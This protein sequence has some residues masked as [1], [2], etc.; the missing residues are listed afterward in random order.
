MIHQFFF[1][2]ANPFFKRHPLELVYYLAREKSVLLNE[3]LIISL[4]QNVKNFWEGRSMPKD[5]RPNTILNEFLNQYSIP[6]KKL[7]ISEM[8][9][10]FRWDREK[11]EFYLSNKQSLSFLKSTD[12]YVTKSTPPKFEDDPSFVKWLK[13]ALNLDVDKKKIDNGHDV[14]MKS[15][16]DEVLEID[17]MMPLKKRK[18]RE[19]SII[20]EKDKTTLEKAADDSLLTGIKLHKYCGFNGTEVFEKIKEHITKEYKFYDLVSDKE[21]EIFLLKQRV[22]ELEKYKSVFEALKGQIENT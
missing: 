22:Y 4:S 21:K 12:L 20:S 13:E 9:N 18:V 2:S 15:S 6:S 10:L 1:I 3:S 5:N 17:S 19:G 16:D 8:R 11:K 7:E 14:V